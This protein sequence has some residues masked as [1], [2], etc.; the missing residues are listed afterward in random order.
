MAVPTGQFGVTGERTTR[1]WPLLTHEELATILAPHTIKSIPWHSQ[2]PFS[3]ASLVTLA[4]GETVFVKRHHP[5]I[6]TRT[7]LAEEHRYIHH[8]HENHLP[9]SRPLPDETGQ[10]IRIH[11]GWIYEVFAPAPGLDLYRDTMSW[12]PF[13]TPAHAHA[14]GTMLARLHT[15]SGGFNAP[16]RQCP[17]TSSMATLTQPDLT[18]ALTLWSTQQP[19][20]PEQ[21]QTRP[22]RSDIAEHIIPFHKTLLP[23]T[24]TLFPLWG[25]GDWHPSNLLW[26]TTSQNAPIST[27]LDFGMANQTCA[28]FDIAV[29]I[30]RTAI[31][32]LALDDT[33]EN[34]ISY[35]TLNAFLE[36]YETQSPLNRPLITAFLPL[37]H[38]EFALSELAYF[39]ALLN[40]PASAENAY[41]TYLLGHARWFASPPGQTLLTHIRTP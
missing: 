12:L 1:D 11:Q 9:V 24:Q 22:W 23:H 6:R 5:W 38:I 36:G 31:A 32:W 16:P 37:A 20:L 29:A 25:H 19:G 41:S 10:T 13:T 30:E 26:S 15:A 40:D 17:L 35:E 33:P 28:E 2:R 27:I 21:L 39:G 34:L 4:N 7:A 3:A 14:A 8:L 18:K